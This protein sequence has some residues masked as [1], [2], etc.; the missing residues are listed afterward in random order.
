M[1]E[2]LKQVTQ[3][4]GGGGLL[5][6]LRRT[7]FSIV[8]MDE[9]YYH[10]L[11]PLLVEMAL[12]LVLIGYYGFVFH[13]PFFL[14]DLP[15]MT[16]IG[17]HGWKDILFSH[18]GRYYRP[19]AFI[20]YK[21]G[22]TMFPLGTQQRILHL[23]NLLLHLCNVVLV[24]EVSKL[25][26][27]SNG[28]AL[29]SGILFSVFPFWSEVIPWITAMPHLLVTML[30]LVS[31]YS[32]LRA[33]RDHRASWWAISF[34]FAVFAPLAHESGAVC[35]VIVAGVLLIQY[36]SG[37]EKLR[38]A[39]IAM[40]S[41]LS[42][43]FVLAREGPAQAVSADWPAGVL[44][45]FHNFVYSLNGL[46]Y[47][48]SP[49]IT[50]TTRRQGW[51]SLAPMIIATVLMMLLLGWLAVGENQRRWMVQGLWWWGMGLLPAMAF[52]P[53]VALY[54]SPRVYALGSVGITMVWAN[55]LVG[56]S[57]KILLRYVRDALLLLIVGVIVLQN[58]N[59]I[60]RE[61]TLYTLLDSVYREVLGASKNAGNIPLGFVNLPSALEYRERVYPTVKDK[62]L[63]VPYSYLNVAEFIQV[64][65]GTRVLAEAVMFGQIYPRTDPILVE[66]GP[67]LG[68]RKMREFAE[69]HRT[70]WLTRYDEG[71]HR[72]TLDYV[73][74]LIPKQ[75]PPNVRPLARFEG[76]PLLLSSSV[77]KITPD[78]W[79]ITLTWYALAPVDAEVFLHV[80]DG[81]NR[82]VTQA[83]GAVIGR[84]IPA[85]LWQRGDLIRDIRYVTL[86]VEGGKSYTIRVGLYRKEGHR[87]PALMGSG[88]RRYSDD[89]VPVATVEP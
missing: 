33:G 17:K 52:L 13:L 89:A 84:M 36:G 38:S 72:F 37:L 53:Y 4:L 9:E 25:C 88:N 70:I 1:R 32:G 69:R 6:T 31:V 55:L 80:V 51:N 76:G 46:V 39:V 78:R 8:P 50:K 20:I 15:I 5:G 21:W 44:T 71:T 66:Q 42:A 62:V 45:P 67:W 7:N 27:Q 24:I 63:F 10:R 2:N 60:F 18:E 19:L 64:N 43:A 34:L 85:Y 58:T 75:P 73:G 14:D 3:W 26:S 30:T 74:Q 11:L 86:P 61:R 68:W 49:A 81:G 65:Q 87:L 59:Y 83:D 47:L 57:R 12:I 41:M 54:S 77:H 79:S 40:G 29:L 23:V 48:I 35:G 22:A 82:I 28:R 56:T 16:W